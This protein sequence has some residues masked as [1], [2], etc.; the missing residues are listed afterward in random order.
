MKEYLWVA[1]GG[2]LGSMLRYTISALTLMMGITS[3]AATFVANICGA[4]LIGLIMATVTNS[5]LLLFGTVGVCGGFTTFSTFSAQTLELFQSGQYALAVG[6]VLA[7]VLACV[8]FVY[9]GISLGRF[10]R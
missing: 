9:L 3:L 4:F 1:L 2:A 5:H 10:I 6:Y 8:L 7:S